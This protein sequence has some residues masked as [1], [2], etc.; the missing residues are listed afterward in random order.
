[1]VI[2]SLSQMIIML[3]IR[4]GDR[5]WSY[6]KGM[7]YS[8]RLKTRTWESCQQENLSIGHL[9]IKNP[10]ICL[11]SILS[12]AFLKISATEFYLELSSD[13]SSVIFKIN[14]KIMTRGKLYIL[15]NIKT[16]WPYFQDLL[17]TT[18]HTTAY[19]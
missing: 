19:H 3:I 15:C 12:E 9:T 2:A 7:N 5:D 18:F 14:S 13:H 10:L 17:K 6:P 8:K 16:K 11:I 1:L 4:T